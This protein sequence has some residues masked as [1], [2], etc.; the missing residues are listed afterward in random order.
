MY[1]S[2]TFQT[3]STSQKIRQLAR[4]TGLPSSV[5]RSI[6]ETSG[7]DSDPENV[8]IAAREILL[9]LHRRK[10][11]IVPVFVE[12]E[13]NLHA[14]AASRLQSLPDW[15]LPRLLFER[16]KILWGSPSI[17]LFATKD[18]AQVARFFAW[19][20]DAEAEAFDA[21]AQLWNFDLAYAFPPPQIISRVLQKIEAASGT[22]ILI[23]PFW[24]AQKWFASIQLLKV[25]EVRKIPPL[26]Q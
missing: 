3:S 17:D 7:A 19:G 1:F 11:E 14:D 22:F 6:I 23:T 15:H 2:S 26:L 18:S 16:I 20:R 25:V 9:M 13:E 12:S 24:P 5:C 21:L 4:T 8:L 10:I